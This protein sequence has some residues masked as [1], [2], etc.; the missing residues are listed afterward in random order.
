MITDEF[1]NFVGITEDEAGVAR[2]QGGDVL[3]RR[4][5]ERSAAPV[6]QLER[7]SVLV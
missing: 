2:E 3:Y 5:L 1:L 7:T 4:L 6:I